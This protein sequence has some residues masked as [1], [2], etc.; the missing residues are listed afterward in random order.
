MR[1]SWAGGR[2][3]YAFIMRAAVCSCL[4]MVGGCVGGSGADSVIS[5]ISQG[6]AN[7]AAHLTEAFLLNLF[8]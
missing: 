7:I 6:L 3:A 8:I 2:L 1:I 5:G 4:A